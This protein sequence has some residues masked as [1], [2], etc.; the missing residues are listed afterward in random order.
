MQAL[1]NP[2]R[3]AVGRPAQVISFV[4]LNRARSSRV[5][6]RDSGP[7]TDPHPWAY[8]FPRPPIGESGDP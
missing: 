1:L 5:L 7:P 8:V 3:D 6:A 4:E 2:R